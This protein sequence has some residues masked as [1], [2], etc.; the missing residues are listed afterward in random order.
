MLLKYIKSLPQIYSQTT[1]QTTL[2]TATLLALTAI[3][4]ANELHK[5]D[6]TWLISKQGSKCFQIPGRV[7][8]SRQGKPNPPIVFVEFKHDPDLCPVKAIDAY[9]NMTKP[10]REEQSQT[11]L[12]L[13]TLAPH[14][15]VAK[16]TIS[17]WIKETLN[18]AGIQGFTGH[19]VRAS[20]SSKAAGKGLS[21]D[22]ILG[23]GN[24]KSRSV[25]EKHYHKPTNLPASQF[26]EV[27]LQ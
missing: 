6:L 11:K 3:S 9:I 27:V 18:L 8:H 25:W 16:T 7:K 17:N 21:L 24:W 15:E 13:S 10:W 2:K 14:K 1:R 4:R 12:F 19:S 20:A 23:R 22:T 5:L 26:Q